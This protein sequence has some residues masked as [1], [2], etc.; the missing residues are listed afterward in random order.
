L[1]AYDPVTLGGAIAVLAAVGLIASYGPAHR[2]SRLD[3]MDAL[4][5][6]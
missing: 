5:E 1:S 3:P 4:R 6:E 2:A